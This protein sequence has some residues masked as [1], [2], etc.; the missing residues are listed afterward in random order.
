MGNMCH[1]IFVCFQKNCIEYVEFRLGIAPIFSKMVKIFSCLSKVVGV[2]K[3]E[4]CPHLYSFKSLKIIP[5]LNP[6]YLNDV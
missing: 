5:K 2:H 4:L 6:M 3:G 1:L